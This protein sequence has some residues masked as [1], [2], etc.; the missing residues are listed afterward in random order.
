MKTPWQIFRMPLLLALLST[1]GL[2]AALLADGWGDVLS[3]ASLAA[4]TGIGLFH[5]LKN[6]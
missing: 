6:G 3:W 4:V 1:V 2:L 5:A